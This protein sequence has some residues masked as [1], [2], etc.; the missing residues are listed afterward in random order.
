MKEA[1]AAGPDGATRLDPPPGADLD[2]PAKWPAQLQSDIDAAKDLAQ[3]APRQHM[4][5]Y[6]ARRRMGC[7]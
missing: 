2:G 5:A 1:P 4:R 6:H 3:N 7:R